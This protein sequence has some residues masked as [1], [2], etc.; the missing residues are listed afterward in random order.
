MPRLNYC[1]F[2]QIPK[3]LNQIER[4]PGWASLFPCL[5]CFMYFFAK[6]GIN[7]KN[8]PRDLWKQ[9]STQMCL[10]AHPHIIVWNSLLAYSMAVD[11]ELFAIST[12]IGRREFFALHLC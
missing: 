2:K 9:T 6:W 10:S 7:L 8:R 11:E 5:V 3:T 4:M 12:C 1:F